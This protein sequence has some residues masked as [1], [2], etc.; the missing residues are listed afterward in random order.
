MIRRPVDRLSTERHRQLL[1]V[2]GRHFAAHGPRG[3]SLNAIL[4]E[5]GVSKGVAYYYFAD[6]D[7]LLAAVLEDAWAAIVPHLPPESAPLDW[8][9]LQALH[10]A[11]LSLLR[12]RPWLA[13]LARHPPPPAV[14]ARLAP[15]MAQ[16]V[17]L[18]PRALAAGLVR[19][20]LPAE[21]VIAMIRGL[22]S[23]IDQWWTTNPTATPAEADLA[24][25]ALRA[26]VAPR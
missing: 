8:P 16:I 14:A 2:A 21:L 10:R 6:K 19:T 3:A 1:D 7:D 17:G 25:A 23:A 26:A 12:A 15:Q 24:F 18:W 11:H 4:A 22:D 13:D 20:D 5:A 9:A